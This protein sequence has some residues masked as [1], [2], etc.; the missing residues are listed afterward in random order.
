MG[1]S[2]DYM[3][4]AINLFES[5]YLPKVLLDKTFNDFKK[6]IY[7]RSGIFL[8]DHKREFLKGR[9]NKRL[10]VLNLTSY[11][12]YY[13]FLVQSQNNSDEW[14]DFLNVIST[15]VTHFFRERHH[16]DFLMQ[17]VFPRFENKKEISIWSA[18]CS[19]GAEP[20]SL[21]IFSR[22]YFSK[23]RDKTTPMISIHASDISQKMLQKAQR[24]VYDAESIREVPQD[25]IYKFFHRGVKGMDGKF[26]VKSMLQENISF[27]HFNLLDPFNFCQRFDIIFCR[28]V[29]IYFD[30]PTITKIVNAF[31][32]VLNRDGYL[33]VGSSESL[34]HMQNLDC[35]HPAIYVPKIRGEKWHAQ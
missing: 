26:K 12:D 30:R 20:Y 4:Q 2:Y 1:R 34:V 21:N 13:R 3:K 18:G 25:L 23:Q 8:S 7:D 28:N 29:M 15:N 32:S 11:E 24:G 33:F 22:E 31:L 16:F 19:N 9:L 5:S 17:Q 10:K 14:T 27:S 35:V 6:I